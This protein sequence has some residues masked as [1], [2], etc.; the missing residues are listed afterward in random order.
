MPAGGQMPQQVHVLSQSMLQP[1][2]QTQTTYMATDASHGIQV[3]MI[4][5]QRPMVTRRVYVPIDLDKKNW[6]I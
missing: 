6:A 3:G 1:Q 2:P 4:D 5:Q